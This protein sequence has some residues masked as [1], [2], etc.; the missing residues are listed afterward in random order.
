MSPARGLWVAS[1]D[2]EHAGVVERRDTVYYVRNAR[3]RELGTFEDLDSA[4]QRIDGVADSAD[5][6]SEVSRVLITRMLWA[7]NAVAFLVAFGLGFVL[8]R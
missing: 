2:G 8:V 3:G 1:R 7:V 5:E 4:C 6:S